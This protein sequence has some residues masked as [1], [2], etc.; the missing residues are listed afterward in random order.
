MTKNDHGDIIGPW[1]S[2]AFCGTLTVPESRG[3]GREAN[4]FAFAG[5]TPGEVRYIVTILS[6]IGSIC[7]ILGLMVTV[8]A[9]YI[10]IKKK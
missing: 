9:L 6:V 2:D 7:S 3:S 4:V 10:T 8:Y 5:N 1:K